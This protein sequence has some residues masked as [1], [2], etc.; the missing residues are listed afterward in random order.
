VIGDSTIRL[1][2]DLVAIDSV[3]PSLVPGA[4]GEADVARRI[5]AELNAIGLRVHITE[6]APGRPNVVGVLDGRA[7]GRTLMLCGHIDTVGVAGMDKPFDPVERDG[8][9]YGRGAQDMKG[10][11]AAM[12]GAARVIAES[13]GLGN[14]RLVI[15]AVIDEEHASLGA[16]ALVTG[17]RADAAV[18]TEP[19]D[20]DIAVAHKGFQWIDIETG[21]RAAHGSRPLEG[22]D[23]IMRMGRVLAGFEALDRRL[24]SGHP[25]PLLGTA[26]LHA[27]TIGGG[28]EW[29]SYPDHCS[30]QV[31]RRTLPGESDTIAL[32]EAS[33]IL[34]ALRDQDSQFEGAASLTFGRSPYEID[35]RETLPTLLA[36]A[37]R[38][39]GHDAMRVGMSF[40]TDAAILGAAGIPSVLFGPGGA[41][42]HSTEEYVRLR[43]VEICRNALVELACVFTQS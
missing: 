7:T 29:S 3:N 14:G 18:V 17:F 32:A 38:S 41:G 5:A 26:S 15:A 28:R 9:L 27:S 19:T 39:A 24:Q 2:R 20:L 35:P 11:V 13:G 1:L 33:A 37:V 42:L 10:G 25:H 36:A 16:D 23:A 4:R 21:G 6:V 8:R 31:E 40:W 12:I 22:R 43:D 30:L 34:D